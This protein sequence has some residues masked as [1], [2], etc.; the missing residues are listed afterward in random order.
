MLGDLTGLNVMFQSNG[1]HLR[2]LVGEIE[3]VVRMFCNNFMKSDELQ[4]VGNIDVND[5][6]C[7]VSIEKVYREPHSRL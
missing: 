4:Q 6:S 2:R 7:L 1:F 5:D 3:R